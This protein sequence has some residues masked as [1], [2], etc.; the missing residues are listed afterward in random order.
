MS[1]NRVFA[2]LLITSALAACGGGSGSTSPKA[3][4]AP[5]SVPATARSQPEPLNPSTSSS[6]P[7]TTEPPSAD[8][9]EQVGAVCEL[10]QQGYET[11]P[12]VDGTVS[13]MTAAVATRRTLLTDAGFESMGLP[14]EA[15]WEVDHVSTLT[16]EA[17]ASLDAADSAASTGDLETAETALLTS[18]DQALRIAQ[19]WILAD[20]PC[21]ADLARAKGAEL[22]VAMEMSPFQ[23]A[24]GYGSIWVVEAFAGRVVRIDPVDGSVQASIDVGERP[25]KLQPADGSM[26]QRTGPSYVRIDPQTNTVTGTLLKTDVGPDA[27]RSWAVDGALWICDGLRLHRYDPTTVTRVSTI[28]LDID[29]GQVYAT[30]DLVVVWTYNED[31]GESGTSA[32]TFIDPATDHVI[33]TVE[34]PVDVG[35]PIVLDDAVFFPGFGGS[36][37]A[38][39]DRST[40]T[41]S[42]TPDLGRAT[43][44]SQS[45]FDGTNLYIAT[46]DHEDILKVDAA[47][48]AV[49]DTITPLHANTVIVADG[50]VWAADGGRFDVVQ[51]FAIAD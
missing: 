29:C 24:A 47:T 39:I 13:G 20:A 10:Q 14:A 30:A 9:H 16:D 5:V 35:V 36:T 25:F 45:G 33:Q 3:A 22:N 23:L 12:E 11:L 41:V 26:W 46:A 1:T 18:D 27:N 50:A 38:V 21:G 15:A 40:W 28:D 42:A 37:A 43:G 34:L 6:G 7:T 4:S 48:Y 2:V 51:R 8:W 19:T 17:L 31:D 44:A 32:A 49:T